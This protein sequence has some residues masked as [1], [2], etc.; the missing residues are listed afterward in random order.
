MRNFLAFVLQ[1]SP[2]SEVRPAR[3]CWTGWTGRTST[4]APSRGATFQCCNSRSIVKTSTHAPRLGCDGCLVRIF[5]HRVQLQLTHPHGVRRYAPHPFLAYWAASTHA[6]PTGCDMS[7]ILSINH[8]FNSRIPCGIRLPLHCLMDGAEYTS[9]H[10]SAPDAKSVF[11]LRATTHALRT[12]CDHSFRFH[13][14]QLQL[15]HP[16]RGATS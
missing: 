3:A 15:T 8:Y 12:G 10:T 6:L 16:V 5:P 14:S 11:S 9:T 4:H 7:C 2:P 13:A 1:L